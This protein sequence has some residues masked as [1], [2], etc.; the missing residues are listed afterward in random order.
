MSA[1][2]SSGSSPSGPRRSRRGPGISLEVTRVAVRNLSRSRD[3]EIDPALLTNDAAAVVVGPRRRPRGRGDRRHRAGTRADHRCTGGWQAGRHG[4]QGTARQRRRRALRHRR[5]GRR[6]P[7]LRGGGRRGHPHRPGAAREPARRA[8]H[9]GHRHRQR[10]DELHPHEDDRAAHDV[11]GGPRRGAAAR[12]CRARPDRRRRGLRRRRQGGDHGDDRHRIQGRRRPGVSRGDQQ[13]QRRRHRRRPSSRLRDQAAR[14]RR[15]RPPP[16]RGRRARASGDGAP[17]PSARQ[18][19]RQLQR[20][21]RRRGRRRLT[22][23]LRPRGRRDAD[24]ERRSRR[25]HRRRR[26][27]RQGDPRLARHVRPVAASARSTS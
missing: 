16:R 17:A 5:A 6:R 7:A 10:H 15:R 26:Q 24:G 8:D 4:Q 2:R 13:H 22:D 9:A 18:R 19:A 14:R 21:V 1:R 27:P 20:R 11:R 23:V 25:H 3:V 12:L